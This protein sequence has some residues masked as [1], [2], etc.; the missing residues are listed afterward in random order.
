M[1]YGELRGTVVPRSLLDTET[2]RYIEGLRDFCKAV[3]LADSAIKSALKIIVMELNGTRSHGNKWS[4]FE[5]VSA[6]HPALA[7]TSL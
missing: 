2:T 7:A 5:I 1:V 6:K 3:T 4:V